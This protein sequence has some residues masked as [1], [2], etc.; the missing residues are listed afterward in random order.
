MSHGSHCWELVI[1]YGV[2]SRQLIWR[3]RISID[4]EQT[5]IPSAWSAG[6]RS[7]NELERFDL[8]IGHHDSNT[9]NDHQ[10][11]MPYSFDI[12]R[13]PWLNEWHTSCCSQ[14]VPSLADRPRR[15]LQTASCHGRSWHRTLKGHTTPAGPAGL[16][17][18]A[19]SEAF[20]P[21]VAF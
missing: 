11:F 8:K 16:V 21:P 1:S 9:R 15:C 18:N 6:T 4:I 20:V 14:E 7:S 13:K 3:S 17:S 19:W 10:S 2:K 5:S 12:S